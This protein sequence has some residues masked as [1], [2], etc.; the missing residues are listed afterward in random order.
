MDIA[1]TIQQI[2]R[3]R[4]QYA[5][6]PK[7]QK[8][9][10]ELLFTK[11]TELEAMRQQLIAAPDSSSD[12]IARL[13]TINFPTVLS[14]IE[15]QYNT[16][17]KV[18]KRFD[19]KTLNI[20]V[21]GRARQGKSTLLQ[22]LTGLT[23]NEIPSGEGMPC[24]SVQSNIYHITEGEPHALVH[25]HSETTFLFEVIAPYYKA[26]NL[27]NPPI[28]IQAFRRSNFPAAPDSLEAETTSLYNHLKDYYNYLDQYAQRLQSE[29]HSETIGIEEVRR[30]VSQ[31]YDADLKPIHFEHLAVRK[32]EI[33]C[34]FPMMEVEKLGLVD[35]IGLGDTRLGD[36]ARM[37]HAL[38]QDVDF[39]MF[40]RRP[41]SGGDF[42]QD[43]DVK[44]YDA[45]YQALKHHLP[46]Q[47]W[48][49]MVLNEDEHNSRCCADLESTRL[50]KGIK[51]SQCITTNCKTPEA[52]S[53]ALANALE[54]LATHLA[55][56]DQRY[57]DSCESGL[58]Q[59]QISVSLELDKAQQALGQYGEE[60]PVYVDLRK[61]FIKD[62]YDKVEN[63]RS[64]LRQKPNEAD[65][66]FMAQITKAIEDCTLNHGIPSV[67][68]LEQLTHLYGINGASFK[69]VQQMRS[70]LL[71]QFH[72]LEAGLRESLEMRKTEMA[73]LFQSMGFDDRFTKAQGT[74][75]LGEINHLIPSDLENL[76]LGFG[77]LTS[78]TIQYKGFI[79]EIVWHHISQ[80]L[81][82]DTKLPLNVPFESAHDFLKER[83]QT[84]I[85]STKD[86]LTV[87]AQSP[88][89]IG[90]SMIEEFS[91]HILRSEQAD[92][93]WD[94]FLYS[95]RYELWQ[96]LKDLSECQSYRNLWLT[97]IEEAT[98][99][100]R[101]LGE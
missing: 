59:L 94:T 49:S 3:D 45:A 29:P 40:V 91:D 52:A 84:A 25:F 39:I 6:H 51:V 41:R 2:I 16:F 21:A 83:H 38:G 97:R 13:Q 34:Q 60:Y 63:L 75:L 19:R 72:H 50:A 86:A 69:A 82:P 99:A 1:T 61:Q 85:Q 46:L 31:S 67:D 9:Y 77:F 65:P 44:L 20:G 68:E 17:D 74:A 7:R 56:L 66:Y 93:E 62:L 12:L 58:K 36:E 92:K 32:V 28:S 70:T 79:Q 15:Q 64:T 81:P 54:Y 96:Q 88:T 55:Q 27:A 37:I 71:R 43:T 42:W 5:I 23:D 8:E 24:T 57:L 53:Q 18:Q 78:F 26:L 30:Y 22:K 14:Q 100:N 95:I 4:K 48:S 10:L 80:A 73:E 101:K 98:I 47:D 76:S 35:T 11:I 90:Q 89:K 33:F 87:L